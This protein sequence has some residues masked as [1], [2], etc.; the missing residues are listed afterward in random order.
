MNENKYCKCGCGKLISSRFQYHLDCKD[1]ISTQKRA[2][3][4]KKH[5]HDPKGSGYIKK[6]DKKINAIL[7]NLNI[8]ADDIARE[9]RKCEINKIPNDFIEI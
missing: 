8:T 1:K 9:V 3:W 2:E 6:S 4:R 5:L 7:D